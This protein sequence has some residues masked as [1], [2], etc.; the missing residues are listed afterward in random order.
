[1]GINGFVSSYKTNFNRSPVIQSHTFI[2]DYIHGNEWTVFWY[3]YGTISSL[4][5]LMHALWKRPLCGW[6]QQKSL[7][8][9]LA[10]HSPI[11]YSSAHFLSTP[12]S[13]MYCFTLS[14]HL[15]TDLYLPLTLSISLTL[16][17]FTNSSLFFFSWWPNHFKEQCFLQFYVK[18]VDITGHKMQIRKIEI[19]NLMVI[20][21]IFLPLFVHKYM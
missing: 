3:K 8:I 13:C 7:L 5:F 1:M 19:I 20:L 11:A 14:F 18:L 4:W 21:V 17:F 6:P 12:L 15:T 10:T 9:Y 2:L 16:T